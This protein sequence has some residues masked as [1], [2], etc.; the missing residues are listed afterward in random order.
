[1]PLQTNVPMALI[2]HSDLV[3]THWI[4][5][6][7]AILELEEVV[8]A[9]NRWMNV[10]LVQEDCTVAR[11]SPLPAT[12]VHQGSM[13]TT[14]NHRPSTLMSTHVMLAQLLLLVLPQGPLTLVA[15]HAHPELSVAKEL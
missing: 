6:K 4:C 3:Q 8:L 7:N 15:P 1:M 11:E 10:M 13:V 9:N 2:A 12:L 5:R 14:T